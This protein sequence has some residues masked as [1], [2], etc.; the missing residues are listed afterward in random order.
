MLKIQMK[1]FIKTFSEY[2]INNRKTL[3]YEKEKDFLKNLNEIIEKIEENIENQRL[4]LNLEELEIEEI[5]INKEVYLKIKEN[6]N[7]E[8]FNNDVL[9]ELRHINSKYTENL[10]NEIENYKLKILSPK[11][12]IAN[13]LIE[14][15]PEKNAEIKKAKNNLKSFNIYSLSVGKIYCYMKNMD[16]IDKLLFEIQLNSNEKE[17]IKS[18]SNE[19]FPLSKINNELKLWINNNNFSDRFVIR[20]R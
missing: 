5:S 11:I 8:I 9:K 14:L 15:I 6:V 18:A 4:L 17:F 2:E 13:I 1:N 19:G 12:E 7:K 3:N 10:K 20:I 16:Y